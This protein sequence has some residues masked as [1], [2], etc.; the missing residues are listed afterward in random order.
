MEEVL[1]VRLKHKELCAVNAK[2]ASMLS[3]TTSAPSVN[4]WLEPFTIHSLNSYNYL[5]LTTLAEHLNLDPDEVRDIV[6]E[7]H[8]VLVATLKTAGIAYADLGSAL[9][10]RRGRHE[11]A[12]I[13]DSTRAD[14][15]M[16]GYSFAELWIPVFKEHGPAKSALRIGDIL[17]L[18]NEVV[19]RELTKH[20]VC[21]KPFPRLARELYFAVYLT[22]LSSGQL[23]QIDTALTNATDAYL[24]YVDCSTW[25]LLKAGLFLPQVG[26]RLNDRIITDM[27]DGETPNP[28]GYPF[29]ESGFEVVGVPQELYGPFLG[30][31]IDNGIPA[32]ADSDSAVGL[33]VLGG[34]QQPVTST[35]ITIN[36]SRVEYLGRSHGASLQQAG[37]ESLDSD[38]LTSAIMS[39]FENGLIYNL[40]FVRGSRSGVPAPDL[41]AMMY[42][43]QVEFPDASGGVKRYQVGLKYTPETHTSEVVTFV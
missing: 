22:N 6:R 18:P 35:K 30:H 19:W 40:R 7:S 33:T 3:M 16:Y 26:L 8:D 23:Q 5:G 43:V 29:A 42:S 14:N 21:R 11:A 9:V 39:K 1:R 4:E 36:A 38:A 34:E 24:G 32:W 31:R 12:F 37:L 25:T 10:P 28:A 17:E 15:G 41:D 2:P 13:F 27:D 20:L